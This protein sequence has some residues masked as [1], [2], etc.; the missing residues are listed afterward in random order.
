VTMNLRDFLLSTAALALA[1]RTEQRAP[2]IDHQLPPNI[3]KADWYVEPVPVPEYHWA[4][5]STYEAFRDMKFGIRLHWGIYS[6]WHRGPESWPFLN[7]TFKDRQEYNDL[8][9]TWNLAGFNAEEWMTLFADSGLNVCI[10]Q[11]TS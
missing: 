6:I 8:Y 3:L 1:T 9:K 5:T 10:H 2:S 7:M 11:Q 4:P